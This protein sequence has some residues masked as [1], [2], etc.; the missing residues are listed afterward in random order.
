MGLAIWLRKITEAGANCVKAFGGWWYNADI[1]Y[2]FRSPWVL[3]TDAD[4]RWVFKNVGFTLDDDLPFDV[5]NL[6]SGV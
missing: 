3:N 5:R 6:L 4:G 1:D 2:S